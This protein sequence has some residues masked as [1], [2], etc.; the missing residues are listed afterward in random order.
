MEFRLILDF[1]DSLFGDEFLNLTSISEV[2]DKGTLRVIDMSKP[3]TMREVYER[4]LLS[5]V[6]S[7]QAFS[8]SSVNDSLSLS[9]ASVDSVDTDTVIQ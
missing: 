7:P 5:P 6:Q 4:S 2:E 9:D 1:K 3:T 8:P